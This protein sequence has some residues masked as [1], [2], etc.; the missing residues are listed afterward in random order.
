LTTI[1]ALVAL[2]LALGG[3]SWLGMGS[4]DDAAD[5]ESSLPKPC[6]SI[7]VLSGADRITIFNGS[8]RDLTDI[9]ARAEIR[10]AVIQCKY[11]TDDSTISVDLAYD[12]TASLGPAA[13]S[14][15]LTLKGFLAIVR[16][17]GKRDS[18]QIYEIPISFAGATREVR[19]TKTIEDTVVSYGGSVNG[20][21]YEF[22]VGFQVTPEQLEYNRKVPGSPL[23]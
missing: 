7:G 1:A 16:T 15:D 20:S 18:K 10:K 14:R 9:V 3:C 11:D 22:L 23:K 4:N 19:F 2:P 6:P 13:T 8:G 12:G 17:D 21:I 5:L